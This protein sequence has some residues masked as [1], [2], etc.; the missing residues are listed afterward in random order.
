VP[1]LRVPD[2]CRARRGRRHGGDDG[3]QPV[4]PE[5]QHRPLLGAAPVG[6]GDIDHPE[7][8]GV[9]VSSSIRDVTEWRRFKRQLQ[10]KNLELENANLAK[11][12]SWR[13]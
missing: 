5:D 12:R 1:L 9:L 3:V 6:E 2:A 8:K 4:D 10:E 7:V 11:D 13:A